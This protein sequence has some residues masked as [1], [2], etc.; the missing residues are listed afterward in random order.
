[1]NELSFDA[2]TTRATLSRATPESVAD[3]FHVHLPSLANE[4]TSLEQT[5]NN[6]AQYF[7]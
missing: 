7:P 1:M 6:P 4:F 2:G 5:S 3:E